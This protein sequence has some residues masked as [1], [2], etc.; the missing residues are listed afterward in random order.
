LA[1]NYSILNLVY[2]KTNSTFAGTSLNAI[3]YF[4]YVNADRI[5][6]NGSTSGIT[7]LIASA[8]A[9]TTSLTLPAATDT[10]VGLATTDTLTNK[11]VTPRVSSAANI[12]SPLAWNGDNFDQYASTAQSEAL[13]INADAGTPTDGQKMIFRFKDN[14]TARA[15]TWTTGTSKSFR[16]VGITLPTTTVASKT[17]YVG[18]VYNSADSRW[19]A[20]AT[21]QEA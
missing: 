10:L 21:S 16:A 4:Q 13:T 5:N 7:G 19:D 14:G 3:D 9:G 15:L 17:L 1:G 12:T 18:C 11:R 20:I 6:F 2:D 8:V